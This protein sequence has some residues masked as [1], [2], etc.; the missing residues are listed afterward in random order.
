MCFFNLQMA[1]AARSFCRICGEGFLK[2]PLTTTGVCVPQKCFRA[3]VQPNFTANATRCG[4]GTCNST[5]GLCS[6]EVVAPN[7]ARCIAA[8]V[9]GACESGLCCQVNGI[10]T[11]ALPVLGE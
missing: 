3:E 11:P 8:G 2:Q 4:T 7:G 6:G 1:N 9:P 5:T 10:L